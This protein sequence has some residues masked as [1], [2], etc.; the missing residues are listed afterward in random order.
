MLCI[1]LQE[2]KELEEYE[3]TRRL[4]RLAETQ[5]DEETE[6]RLHALARPRRPRMR[7]VVLDDNS[8]QNT[9]TTKPSSTKTSEG[10]L[11]DTSQSPTRRGLPLPATPAEAEEQRV[12]QALSSRCGVLYSLPPGI[13]YDK[14]RKLPG[15]KDQTRLVRS[16]DSSFARI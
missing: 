2:R 9:S 8:A 4:K 6:E 7:P 13:D 14:L 16:S 15:P 11:S 5:F 10:S 12:R 1:P 3:K